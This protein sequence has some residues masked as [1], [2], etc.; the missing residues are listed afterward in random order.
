MERGRVG[1]GAVVAGARA[2]VQFVL[3]SRP[4]RKVESR[5]GPAQNHVKNGPRFFEFQT[6][7]ARRLSYPR[8]LMTFRAFVSSVLRPAVLAA[9]AWSVPAVQAQLPGQVDASF[10]PGVFN[11]PNSELSTGFRFQGADSVPG[12]SSVFTPGQ[13][14]FTTF[15]LAVQPQFDNSDGTLSGYRLIVAGDGSVLGRLFLTETTITRID[16]SGN[17][18]TQTFAPGVIDPGFNGSPGVTLGFGQPSARIIYALAP[19]EDGRII[20]AGNFGRPNPN[21]TGTGALKDRRTKILNIGRVQPNGGTASTRDADPTLLTPVDTDPFNININAQGGADGPITAL[22]R[23]N[24]VNHQILVGGQFEKFNGANQPRL[25]QIN[26]DGTLDA[27]FNRNLGSGPDGQIFSIAE[28]VDPATGLPNGRV[29]IVGTFTQVG[30]TKVSKIAR[31][32]GDGTLDTTFAAKIDQRPLAV[33]VQRDG[34]VLVGGDFRNVNGQGRFNLA[35]LNADGSLDAGFLE[36]AG[37]RESNPA[38][39]P[40]T[41]VYAIKV[42][43]DGRILIGGNFLKLNSEPR[44]YLGRLLADGTLDTGFVISPAVDLDRPPAQSIANAVQSI[45]LAPDVF[46]SDPATGLIPDIVVSTTRPDKKAVPGDKGFY[47]GSVQRV[48]NDQ[49]F[50]A[51]SLGS[52]FPSLV[53]VRPAFFNGEIP[54][55]NSNF[56]L[57]FSTTGNNFGFYSYAFFPFLYHFDLGFVYFLDANDGARGA[58]LYDFTSGSFFY[59]SP[60]FPFPYLYDFSLNALLYYFPDANNPGRYTS[61]PRYFYNF[62]TGQVITK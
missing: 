2:A 25:V 56:F 62:A 39:L 20:I 55:G 8:C 46:V 34:K 49:T 45:V 4:P 18:F 14:N 53:P 33:A 1:A 44:L 29:Y 60:S 28:D 21:P 58:Y 15:A 3:Q 31:L 12:L 38:G 24:D 48:L 37:V 59:T 47:P 54:L 35:R 40:P 22:L 43:P 5:V 26:D 11:A 50:S 32:N 42:Q 23:R 61:N 19:Q 41:A 7:S 17:P 16:A 36:S 30:A 6:C 51:A 57:R 13:N 9:V 27:A 52:F 10:N